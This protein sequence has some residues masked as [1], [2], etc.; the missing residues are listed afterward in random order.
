MA[1]VPTRV[2]A[3]G[4]PSPLGPYPHAVVARGLVFCSGQGARDPETGVVAGLALDGDGRVVGHD[5]R[6]MTEVCL[7]NVERVLAGAGATLADVVELQVFLVDMD[8]FAAMNEVYARRFAGGGP[9]RTTVG[10]A[11]LPAGNYVEMRAVAMAPDGKED[12]R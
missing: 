12:Q 11:S 3:P 9:A 8:D 7:D 5:A 6:V 1:P 2:S 4:A 10:V